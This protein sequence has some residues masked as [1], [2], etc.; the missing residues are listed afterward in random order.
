MI[1]NS[2]FVEY[3]RDFLSDALFDTDYSVLT[4][5]WDLFICNMLVTVT[6]FLTLWFFYKVVEK[7]IS[8]FGG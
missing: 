7:V 4:N 5:E 6:L 8:I 2:S 1:V 3:A